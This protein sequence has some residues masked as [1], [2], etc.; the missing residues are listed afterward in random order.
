[1]YD[2]LS[3]TSTP[4]SPLSQHGP[5]LQPLKAV[6]CHGPPPSC[7]TTHPPYDI[8][9]PWLPPPCSC[10]G[11]YFFHSWG[12][13]MSCGLCF[14]FVLSVYIWYIVF[15]CEYF[16]KW[17]HQMRYNSH[18]THSPRE[19][20]IQLSHYCS[21]ASSYRNETEK[22]PTTSKTGPKFQVFCSPFSILLSFVLYG[23]NIP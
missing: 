12:R 11:I 22:F 13:S 6:S 2:Q 5:P 10:P 16:T 14:P 15:I 3:F 4:P 9:R 20:G 23:R 7:H 8:P 21:P 1:M 17:H 18:T 19:H